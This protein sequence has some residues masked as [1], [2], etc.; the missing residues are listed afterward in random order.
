MYVYP[1]ECPLPVSAISPFPSSIFPKAEPA[2]VSGALSPDIPPFSAFPLDANQRNPENRTFP[3]K[4][5]RKVLPVREK[6]VP[7]HSLSGKRYC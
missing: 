2:T 4:K 5:S 7:L 1:C 3:E 6:A